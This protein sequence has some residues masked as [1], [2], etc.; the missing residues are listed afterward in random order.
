MTELSTRL[1]IVLSQ[2]S[3]VLQETPRS[4][5]PTDSIHMSIQ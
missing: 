2:D 4:L 1:N 5:E 3:I